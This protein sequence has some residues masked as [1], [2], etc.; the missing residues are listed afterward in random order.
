M[1]R[2]L[3]TALAAADAAAGLA[4][5]YYRGEFEVELKEDQTPVTV[6]DRRCED[7]IRSTL[8]DAF[9]DHGFYG[10]E[11]GRRQADADGDGY[12][13]IEE[14]LN[15]WISMY[16]L[17]DDTAPQPVMA[18][19]PLRDARVEVTNI[20]GKAGAYQATIYLRPHFQLEEL[21]TS[22]RLEVVVPV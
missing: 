20:E 8:L 1:E 4:M 3:K 18:S 10:E 9:P 14:Y 7:I 11:S 13:N 22:I 12:T 2:F 6:A 21:A 17:L 15:N 19:Y 5:K 16:V